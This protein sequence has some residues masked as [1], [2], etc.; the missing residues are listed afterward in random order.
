MFIDA[1]RML[2]EASVPIHHRIIL[3]HLETEPMETTTTVTETTERT[4]KGILDSLKAGT[5]FTKDNKYLVSSNWGNSLKVVPNPNRRDKD[6][7]LSSDTLEE[8]NHLSSLIEL[9]QEKE[10]AEWSISYDVKQ[11]NKVGK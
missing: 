7:Y 3:N 6:V 4:A 11:L 8:L 2:D 1:G 9:S 5:Y 10:E